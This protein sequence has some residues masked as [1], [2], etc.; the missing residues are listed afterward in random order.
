M[1]KDP[2]KK[3]DLRACAVGV[4]LCRHLSSRF[5]FLSCHNRIKGGA[6]MHRRAEVIRLTCL[7]TA[8]RRANS[9]SRRDLPRPGSPHS[10]STGPRQQR[11]AATPH[12]RL[13]VLFTA[14]QGL[15]LPL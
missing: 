3:Q 14:Y 10:K 1:V 12:K 4:S 9:A 11:V 15:D 13:Q 6:L 8:S 2:P 5:P 7:S